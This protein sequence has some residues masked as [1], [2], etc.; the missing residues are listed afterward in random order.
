VSK[1]SSK[2]R[3]HLTSD[4]LKIVEQHD[5]LQEEIARLRASNWALIG[6]FR[7]IQNRAIQ[8]AKYRERAAS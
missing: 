2:W 4:E 8:R 1:P 6:E 3:E 5:A 7:T